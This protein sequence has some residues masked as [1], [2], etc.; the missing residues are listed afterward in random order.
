MRIE[1]ALTKLVVEPRGGLVGA[2]KGTADLLRHL[3]GP[4][5]E[6]ATAYLSGLLPAQDVTQVEL[7][8]ARNDPQ[9]LARRVASYARAAAPLARGPADEE[10]TF[11]VLPATDPG[12]V[13]AR[14]VTAA[15]PGAKTIPVHGPGTDLLFCREQGCLRTADLARL[16]EPCLDAYQAAAAA[17]ETNPH[18]RFDVTTWVPLVE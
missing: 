3:G 18:S 2:S 8:S 1:Q 7:S 5:V 10:R 13:Y 15:V 6:Q 12:N 16:L 17:M 11:V 4:L 14:E 9:E